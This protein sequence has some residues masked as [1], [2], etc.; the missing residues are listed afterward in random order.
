MFI[1]Y[2]IYGFTPDIHMVQVIYYS[3]CMI[4][5]AQGLDYFN[6][7][8][9]V[10]FRDWGQ[11]INI[12][13]SVLMWATPIMWNMDA[14]IAA[15]RLHGV[16]GALLKLNPMYYVVSGYRDAM[17]NGIWFFERPTITLYFWVLV[18]ALN[19]FGMWFFHRLQPHFADM[20]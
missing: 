12:F 6:S 3:L 7:A 8:L 16:I 15:G 17:I 2:F 14:M 10:F 19:A 11:V 9:V 20:M 1:M 18:V 5:L 13:M 4:F